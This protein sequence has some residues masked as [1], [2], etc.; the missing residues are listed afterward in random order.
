MFAMRQDEQIIPVENLTY[1]GSSSE[2][3]D[4]VRTGAATTFN[5][6]QAKNFSGMSGYLSMDLRSLCACAYGQANLF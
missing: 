5:G 4:I 3:C 6:S 2:D 1:V